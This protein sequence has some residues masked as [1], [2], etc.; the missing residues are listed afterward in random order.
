MKSV[1]VT[2]ISAFSALSMVYVDRPKVAGTVAVMVS[3]VYVTVWDILVSRVAMA[4]RAPS[5]IMSLVAAGVSS[6]AATGR[7]RT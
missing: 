5:N 6:A 3:L 7:W 2:V 1:T 4:E